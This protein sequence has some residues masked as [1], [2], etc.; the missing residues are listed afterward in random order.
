MYN[1]WADWMNEVGFDSGY[2]LH[3]IDH[4]SLYIRGDVNS[5]DVVMCIGHGARD[6]ERGVMS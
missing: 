2:F 5:C 3:T 1:M 6:E 4:C